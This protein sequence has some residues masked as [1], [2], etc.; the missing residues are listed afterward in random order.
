MS[1]IAKSDV[2]RYSASIGKVAADVVSSSWPPHFK[3]LLAKS[4]LRTCSDGAEHLLVDL[5]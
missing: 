5:G 3:W 2:A 4:A 1:F